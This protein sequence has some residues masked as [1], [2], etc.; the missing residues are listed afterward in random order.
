MANVAR[1]A[2]VLVWLLLG[3]CSSEPHEIGWRLGPADAITGVAGGVAVVR[4]GACEADGRELHRTTFGAAGEGTRSP[5][6]EPGEYCFRIIAWT[7][8][9]GGFHVGERTVRLPTREDI[10]ITLGERM[11]CAG[12][13]ECAACVPSADMDGG[14]D[15]GIDAG[16][17]ADAPVTPDA[18]PDALVDD[19]DGDTPTL[20]WPHPGATTGSVRALGEVGVA[21]PVDTPLFRWCDARGAGADFCEHVA[22]ASYE[23]VVTDECAPGD[24]DACAFATSV[25]HQIR[26]AAEGGRWTLS[27][28]LGAGSTTAPVGRRLFWRVR[29]WNAAGTCATPWSDVWYLDQGRTDG[30]VDGDGYANVVVGDP[31]RERVDVFPRLVT[32][33]CG[34]T[35]PEPPD[36]ISLAADCGPGSGFGS[37]V[38]H[39]GDVDADGFGDLVAG[40]PGCGKAYLFFG[41]AA[42]SAPERVEI[43]NPDSLDRTHEFGFAVAGAG[44]VDRDGYADFVI[45]MPGEGDVESPGRVRIFY[46]AARG[47]LR[48]GPRSDFLDHPGAVASDRFGAE[49]AGAGDL[50]AD[51]H[52][53]LVVLARPRETPSGEPGPG[54]IFAGG[55]GEQL[56]QAFGGGGPFAAIAAGVGDVD[57]SGLSS[58]FVGAPGMTLTGEVPVG[59]SRWHRGRFPRDSTSPSDVY[60]FDG[61]AEDG[62]LGAALAAARIGSDDALHDVAVGAPQHAGRGL[63]VV[64]RGAVGAGPTAG[65]RIDLSPGS[66]ARFGESVALLDLSGDG[67][68]ELVVGAP[69]AA[70]GAGVLRIVCWSDGT[71]TSW[72]DLPGPVGSRDY[73]A[74]LARGLSH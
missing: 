33:G 73:G 65:E 63:V 5:A 9:C 17:D 74:V 11:D 1:R 50:D 22:A 72:F 56:L 57:D 12:A 70:T 39:A 2:Q 4:E 66:G 43:A 59:F 16:T 69:G 13:P 53:D 19:C 45:G 51:G 29:R 67:R 20:L 3:A 6:L 41:A 25:D 7:P 68:A 18:A 64:H 27:P 30:D 49:V 34:S 28:K 36:P 58:F 54:W 46:G 23:V 14:V 10:A 60:G 47:D 24:L 44:D 61:R 26:F 42:G 52:A 40:A 71:P 48:A 15:S 55:A 31:G 35:V 37:A 21:L 8:D 32:T 62:A 38:A